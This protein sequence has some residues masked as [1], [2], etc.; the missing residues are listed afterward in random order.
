MT[1]VWLLSFAVGLVFSGFTGDAASG[2][3]GTLNSAW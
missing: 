3:C 2:L 1:F